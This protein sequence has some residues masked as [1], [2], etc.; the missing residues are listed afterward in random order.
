MWVVT[1]SYGAIVHRA[2]TLKACGVWID[3][4][5]GIDFTGRIWPDEVDRFTKN[6]DGSYTVKMYD[7]P[8]GMGGE[9]TVR[10]ATP[11]D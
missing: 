1:D 5:L 11:N 2:R 6:P 9:L 3:P 4:L 8:G 7:G 10:K